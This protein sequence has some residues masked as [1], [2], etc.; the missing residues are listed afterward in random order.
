ML[1][2]SVLPLLGCYTDI[3]LGSEAESGSAAPQADSPV[4]D[5]EPREQD[6]PATQP[7]SAETEPAEA[8]PQFDDPEEELFADVPAEPE[9]PEAEPPSGDVPAATEAAAADEDDDDFFDRVFGI[10]TD[11]QSESDAPAQTADG[12]VAQ[13]VESPDE[14]TGGSP[15]N[16]SPALL[17]W[18]TPDSRREADPSATASPNEITE[19]PLPEQPPNVET[20]IEEVASLDDPVPAE[21]DWQPAAAAPTA[22]NSRQL[23]WLLSSRMSYMLIAPD[24]NLDAMQ[25]ELAPLAKMLNLELPEAKPEAAG[26]TEQFKQVLALGRTLGKRVADR[27]GADQAALVEVAFKSNLLLAVVEERPQLKHSINASVAAAAVRA[28]LPEAVWQDFQNRVAEG[29]TSSEIGQAVVQL[30]QQVGD[31]LAKSP[32]TDDARERA[33]LR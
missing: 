25:R 12:S 27:Y 30:H 26:S 11:T 33:V 18:E 8:L 6:S 29:S 17:P 15:A 4:A 23:I 5:G 22:M 10:Q 16:E 9:Q 24:G 28:G 31:L 3:E 14:G 7:Q 32:P 13:S 20:D 21:G 19:A 1:G 2:L